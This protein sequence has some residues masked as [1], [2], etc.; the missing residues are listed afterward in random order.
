MPKVALLGL[1][2]MGQGVGG[3]LLAHDH[4]LTV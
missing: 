2:V 3:R 1:G 4:A